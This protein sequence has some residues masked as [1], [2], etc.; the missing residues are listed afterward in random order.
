MKLILPILA[1]GVSNATHV[2]SWNACVEDSDC[3]NS[4]SELC[5]LAYKSGWSDAYLCGPQSRTSVPTDKGGIYGGFNFRCASKGSVSR[6]GKCMRDSDCDRPDINTCCDVTKDN[7]AS[8]KVCGPNSLSK[9][10]TVPAN[11][12][13]DYGGYTFFCKSDTIKTTKKSSLWGGSGAEYLTAATSM[14]IL[15]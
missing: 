9:S 3:K 2:L 12:E 13:G 6:W 14:S 5:C 11:L 1:V 8:A 10:M 15:A 7:A 4:N